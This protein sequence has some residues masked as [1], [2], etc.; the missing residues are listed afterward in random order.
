MKKENYD[1]QINLV[2]FTV[3][4]FDENGV[5][6]ECCLNDEKHIELKRVIKETLF[7]CEVIAKKIKGVERNV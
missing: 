5:A 3:V 1:T 2:E 6:Y 4:G 7:N